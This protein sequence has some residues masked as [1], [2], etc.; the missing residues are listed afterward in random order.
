MP[1]E[2]RVESR[3][4]KTSQ[5]RKHLLWSYVLASGANFPR[6]GLGSVSGPRWG[7]LGFC[8]ASLNSEAIYLSCMALALAEIFRERFFGVNNEEAQESPC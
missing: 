6:V 8:C 5:H 7:T 4:Q 1:E 2:R 3:I